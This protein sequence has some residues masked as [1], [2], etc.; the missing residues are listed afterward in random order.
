MWHG[1]QGFVM[2]KVAEFKDRNFIGGSWV[3]AASG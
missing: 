3:T 1:S 2:S